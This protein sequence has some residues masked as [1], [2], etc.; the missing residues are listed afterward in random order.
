MPLAGFAKNAVLKLLKDIGEACDRYH[1]EHV[2][3]LK[4]KRVQC[5]EIWSFVHAKDKNL[6]E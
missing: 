4:S 1:N 5:D 3:N 2:R 6:S